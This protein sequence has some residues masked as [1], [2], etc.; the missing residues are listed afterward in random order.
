VNGRAAQVLAIITRLVVRLARK[1][2]NLELRLLKLEYEAERRRC[3]GELPAKCEAC[4]ATLRGGATEHES[5]CPI[6]AIIKSAFPEARN[7][8][9]RRRAVAGRAYRGSNLEAL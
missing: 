2:Y 5:S 4:G 9:E 8:P 3:L 7:H 6:L 1:N